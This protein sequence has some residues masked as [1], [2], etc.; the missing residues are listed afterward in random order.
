MKDTRDVDPLKK[1]I[2]IFVLG[3]SFTEGYYLEDTVASRIEAKLE[4]ETGKND[5][6]VFNVGTDSY[7]PLLEYL[8]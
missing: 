1:K 6:E 7:S 2:R 3:D 5:F 4:S 8:R